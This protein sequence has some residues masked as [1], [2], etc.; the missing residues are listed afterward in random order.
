MVDTIE[1]DAEEYAAEYGVLKGDLVFIRNNQNLVQTIEQIQQTL[2]NVN[3]EYDNYANFTLEQ[4]VRFDSLCAFCV[5]ALF[6]MHEKLLG[7]PTTVMD[8]IKSDLDRVREAMKR[9]QMVHDNLTKRPHLDKPAAKR[10]I[11]AGLYD[12][13]STPD[14]SDGAPPNKKKRMKNRETE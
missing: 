3:R 13:N 5:N 4:K 8:D 7:R 14:K 1:Q 10:F 12:L 11:R 6:W 2:A 9:L